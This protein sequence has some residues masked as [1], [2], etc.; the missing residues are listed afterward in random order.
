MRQALPLVQAIAVLLVAAF[1]P[2][3]GH[4]RELR[5]APDAQVSASACAA[6]APSLLAGG[7][8]STPLTDGAMLA[9]ACPSPRCQQGLFP[10]SF[11]MRP[12]GC[13]AWRCCVRR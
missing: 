9:Q 11:Q 3:E 10:C 5:V 1:A 6:S 4:A 2:F 12:N 8:R 13:V 7:P